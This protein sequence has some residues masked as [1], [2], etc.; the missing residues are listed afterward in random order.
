MK[1]LV[2][3]ADAEMNSKGEELPILTHMREAASSPV[4]RHDSDR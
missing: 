3:Q 1:K 4:G 2:F